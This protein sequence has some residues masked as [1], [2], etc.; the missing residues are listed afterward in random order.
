MTLSSTI[1]G[2]TYPYERVAAAKLSRQSSSA[3][4]SHASAMVGACTMIRSRRDWIISISRSRF[5][6]GVRTRRILV[7]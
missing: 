4:A 6:V 1:V 5:I 7:R 2:R 3:Q